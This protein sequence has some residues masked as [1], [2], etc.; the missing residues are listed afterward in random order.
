MSE[1]VHISKKCGHTHT[2]GVYICT[3]IYEVY[4]CMCVYTCVY[5]CVHVHIYTH[6]HRWE[7]V[8]L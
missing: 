6:I 7:K 4:I 1:Y 5:M 8:G 2:W 3:H